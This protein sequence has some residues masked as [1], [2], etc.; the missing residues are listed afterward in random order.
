MFFPSGVSPLAVASWGGGEGEG[1]GAG[2]LGFGT[3]VEL[4]FG[5][6]MVAALP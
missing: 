2:T 4:P 1:R 5:Q 3:G 6:G